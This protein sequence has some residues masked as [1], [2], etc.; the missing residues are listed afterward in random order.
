MAKHATGSQRQ[1]ALEAARIICE[2][3]LT[4]YRLAKLKAA[5]R[6]GIDPR[7][8]G[9]P[10]NA[11]IEDAVIEYQRLFGGEDYLRHLRA[12][13]QA[14]LQAMDLLSPFAPRLVGAVASGAVTEAHI[15]RLHGFADKPEMLDMFL[16]D[17]GIP[18]APGER[19]YRYADGRH[20]DVPTT[21]FEA[22]EIG[23]EVAMFAVDDQRRAPLSPHDG[24]PMKRLGPAQ[25]RKL[26]NCESAVD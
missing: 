2:Q 14:A 15:V 17:R 16:E 9:F 11:A 12:L 24:Q 21:R 20:Q 7:R 22:G 6:L 3:Q 5:E 13:R 8:S 10:D 26:L 23:V 18:Y 4:D 19:R 1:M 25:L